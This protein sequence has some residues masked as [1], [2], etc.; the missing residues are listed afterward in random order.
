MSKSE[1]TDE[2]AT[3]ARL[4]DD[5]IWALRKDRMS[6]EQIARRIGDLGTARVRAV[7]DKHRRLTLP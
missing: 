7:C 5:R 3:R 4:L 6:Y 2:T 1:T